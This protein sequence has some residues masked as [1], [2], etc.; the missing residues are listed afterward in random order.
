MV[1]PGGRESLD[2]KD[3]LQRETYR[4]DFFQAVRLL[5]RLARE[6]GLPAPRAGHQPVGA[7]HP[8]ERECIRFRA[9]PSLS[10]P[11]AAASRIGRS[12]TPD[13]AAESDKSPLEMMV[14]FLGLTGPAGVLPPHYTALL[15]RRVRAKDLSLRDLL[16]LFNHR[17]VSLFYRAWE[18]YRLPFAYERSR[19]D[20]IGEEPERMTYALYSVVGR[21]TAGLR[22]RQ[23]IPDEAFL[24]YGGHF[25]HHPRS[26]A[27]LELLLGD[28][29]A[30]PVQVHQHQGH[31]LRLER[32]DQAQLPSPRQPRGRNN[33]L[34]FDLVVGERVWGVQ[35]KFRLR[36]GPL[37]YRQFLS[38][39]PRVGKR[40]RP[41]GQMARSYVGPELVFDVQLVLLAAE[42]PRVQLGAQGEDRPYLGW[43]TWMHS[44]PGT[45]EVDDAV[46]AE[47]QN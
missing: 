22:G 45:G 47:E 27:A 46:F 25:A 19:L 16:D 36:V 12:R 5:E 7:D 39:L 18:K 34:G 29:F 21:G 13:G 42:A 20:G 9:L 17:L 33:R 26:A 40:L 30:L 38:F 31:W 10:F 41:F 32:D 11:T 8:P 4:F 2:L 24:Y 1:T 37:T 14:A 6:G 35:S 23:E 43:N 28:Y 44:V 3:R 15:M